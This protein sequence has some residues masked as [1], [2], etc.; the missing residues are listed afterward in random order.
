MWGAGG[1][2]MSIVVAVIDVK[3]GDRA[4]GSDRAVSSGG[5]NV[6]TNFPKV[7]KYG[8][9][10]VGWVGDTK[11]I[12]VMDRELLESSTDPVDYLRNRP[13]KTWDLVSAL[14]V[15]N[16]TMIEFSESGEIYYAADYDNN[17]NVAAIGIGTEVAF[18]AAYAAVMN[19]NIPSTAVRLALEACAQYVSG[20][21]FQNAILS[22][23][24][25]PAVINTNADID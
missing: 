13:G 20:I 23:P 16:L 10:L 11:T 2:C 8:D 18:G 19:G 12:Q 22:Q 15:K 1:F 17:I 25:W 3:T 14:V 6:V 24:Y 5:I 9:V 7:R 4:I 21:S